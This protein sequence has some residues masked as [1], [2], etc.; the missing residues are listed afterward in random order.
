M[1]KAQI[2]TDFDA[3][4]FTANS[5]SRV[6]TKA[7]PLCV[8]VCYVY[9]SQRTLQSLC[10]SAADWIKYVNTNLTKIMKLLQRNFLAIDGHGAKI[11]ILLLFDVY[12]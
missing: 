10:A 8:C 7:R 3:I 1:N 9:A 6:E 4:Q 2:D 12:I 11:L 5:R